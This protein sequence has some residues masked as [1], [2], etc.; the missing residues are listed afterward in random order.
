MRFQEHRLPRHADAFWIVGQVCTA[1]A[2]LAFLTAAW[3]A[4][5][6]QTG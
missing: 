4:A 1:L 6:I 3:W 5:F 2:P